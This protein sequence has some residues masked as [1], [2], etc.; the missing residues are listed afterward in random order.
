MLADVAAVGNEVACQEG[1]SAGEGVGTDGVVVKQE[2]K[3]CDS[4]TN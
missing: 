2:A 4:N 3:K 1:E